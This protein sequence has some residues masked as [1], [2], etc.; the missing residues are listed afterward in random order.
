MLQIPAVHVIKLFEVPVVA[1]DNPD[2][3]DAVASDSKQHH[4]T[5]LR[6]SREASNPATVVV[7]IASVGTPPS[8]V[9]RPD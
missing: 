1:G 9:T 8:G 7:I 2:R 3:Y 5:H 6:L 4:I